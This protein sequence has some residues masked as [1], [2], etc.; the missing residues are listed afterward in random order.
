MKNIIYTSK[1]SL[2][3]RTKIFNTQWEEVDGTKVEYSPTGNRRTLT[4]FGSRYNDAM[5]K[6]IALAV[7][8]T[9]APYVYVKIRRNGGVIAALIDTGAYPSYIDGQLADELGLVST[10]NEQYNIQGIKYEAPVYDEEI[11]FTAEPCHHELWT[12][13]G[14]Q[15]AK[16]FR[17]NFSLNKHKIAIG[18][19]VLSKCKLVYDGRSG[20]TPV[21]T[22]E[23][24]D[25]TPNVWYPDKSE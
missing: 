10:R 13:I 14:R 3:D 22:L 24:D 17:A 8:V 19:D 25:T 2:S 16:L 18:C 23:F 5:I 9:N 6:I 12:S 4:N 7:E 21:I 20:K 1:Q 11:S 15:S